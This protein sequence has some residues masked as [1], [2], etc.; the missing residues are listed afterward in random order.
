MHRTTLA[1][2][3]DGVLSGLT[4]WLGSEVL[5]LPNPGAIDALNAYQRAGIRV[6]VFSARAHSERARFIMRQW[7]TQHGVSGAESIP[8]T[9]EKTLASVYLDDRAWRFDGTFPSA[10]ELKAFR[11]WQGR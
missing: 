10:A 4:Q 6:I 2:D 9:H 1:I 5:G 11:T 7:L 3:F 8:I